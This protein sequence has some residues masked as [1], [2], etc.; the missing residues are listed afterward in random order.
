[1]RAK[2]AALNFYD[3]TGILD[4]DYESKKVVVNPP[5][6]IFIPSNK[7]KK[8]LLIGGRDSSLLTRIID[9]A[10]K[11]DLE[12]QIKKQ[13]MS[14]RFLLLP[15]VITITS[16][17]TRGI[18]S[19]ETSL[20]EFAAELNIKFSNDYFPQI[21][22]QE[23]SA[24]ITDYDNS[25]EL[26]DENDYGWA[27]KIFNSES[28]RYERDENQNFDKSFSLIEYKLNEYTYYN[29]LWKGGRCFSVDK[30]WGRFIALKYYNRNVI[31]FDDRRKRVAIP[32][33]TPLPRL[34][35]ES[36]MLLSGFAPDFLEV[37]GKYYRVYEN[38]PGIF[39][40]NLFH[41]LGQ[42]PL[43]KELK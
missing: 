19:W 3:Y 11:Y 12:V 9:N 13:F 5:Q 33:E 27:R 10:R 21:A 23:F 22:L 34:L 30:N 31:F 4:F 41:K 39:T 36:M 14:N 26:M 8:V 18:G 37:N 6:L 40:E 38:I 24:N 25:L 28:L 20:I 17:S 43:K 32:I 29:K 7:G 16:F 15:D 42:Q 35:S 2:R 1:M